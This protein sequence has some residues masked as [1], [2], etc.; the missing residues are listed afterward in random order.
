MAGDLQE[1]KEAVRART[2]LVELAGSY[3]ALKRAGKNFVGLCPFHTDRKPSFHVSP[4]LQIYKCYACGEGG[5]V[6]RFVQKIENLEFVEA[7]EFLARRAG[8]TFERHALD[9]HAR[10]NREQMREINRAALQFFK[11]RLAVSGEARDYLAR[12]AVLRPTQDFWEIGYAPQEWD[13][14]C[15]IDAFFREYFS[16]QSSTK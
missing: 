12:R 16:E 13:A 11:D 7:L 2:D 10:S 1:V 9:P 8:V 5:D 15:T 3:L 14:H 6:F 4:S